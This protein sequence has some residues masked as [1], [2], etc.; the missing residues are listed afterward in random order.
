MS[1]RVDSA[2]VNIRKAIAATPWRRW[3]LVGTKRSAETA[4]YIAQRRAA[5]DK[6][7]PLTELDD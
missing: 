1:K 6:P 2:K 3:N 4:E 5:G 7:R